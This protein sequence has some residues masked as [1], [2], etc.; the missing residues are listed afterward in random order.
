MSESVR[1]SIGEEYRDL[2][3]D[4]SKFNIKTEENHL[5]RVRNS[6][7][8][9]CKMLDETDFELVS[10]YTKDKEKVELKYKFNDS[11]ILNTK[12]NNFKNKTYK[13]IINF[14]NNIEK[15]GDKLV[16][17]VDLTKG[18]NLVAQIITFDK[19]EI[20]IDVVNYNQWN[21]GRLDF[22]SKLKEV[23]GYTNE[24]YSNNETKI[25]IYIDDVK[26]NPMSVNTFKTYTYKAIVNFKNNLKQNNDGFISFIGLNYQGNLIAKIR[27]FDGGIVSIDI[28]SYC[29][30]N[31]ARQNTY[32]YCKSKGYRVLSPYVNGQE[33]ILIDF[34]CGHDSH[35]IIPHALK[36]NQSCPICKE[37]KGE[38][39]IRL[40]LE[41]NNID[42]IQ[43]YKFEDCR[44]KR[45][46]PFDF[47]IPSFNL[48]IEFDGRQHFEGEDFFGGKEG[49][50][51]TQTRDKVKD[52]YCKENKIDLLRIPYWELDNIE[53]ILD[54]EFCKLKK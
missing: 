45:S 11:I 30:F 7:I 13:T 16:K 32:N 41:D 43:E 38:K 54:E 39:L 46:L 5:T 25:D 22:Y 12:P 35:W 23:N 14:K 19:K 24:L 37:S 1:E 50:K 8:K 3:I 9:F 40:Y 29:Q 26:L 17:F 51:L 28:R 31:K 4:W 21:K 20:N 33:K 15:N 52:S 2:N 36:N 27:T 49:F 42:F 48:C 6:Y 44:N 53:D 10:N 18:G 34:G 47:Y